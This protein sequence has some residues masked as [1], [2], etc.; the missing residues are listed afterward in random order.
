MNLTAKT[1]AVVVGGI[2]FFILSLVRHVLQS[3][4]FVLEHTKHMP[5]ARS[6]LTQCEMASLLAADRVGTGRGYCYQPS[7]LNILKLHMGRNIYGVPL[8]ILMALV[9]NIR[10]LYRNIASN[11]GLPNLPKRLTPNNLCYCR[12]HV[13]CGTE[14]A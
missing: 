12:V 10:R 1:G 14:I 2:A 6:F 3:I 13:S 4:G 7:S 5:L 11:S 8:T 9:W